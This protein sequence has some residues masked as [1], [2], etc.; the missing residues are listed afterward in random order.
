MRRAGCP[1][2]TSLDLRLPAPPRGIS[3]R[4]RVLPRPP[5]PRHPPCALLAE[6]LIRLRLAQSASWPPR[7]AGPARASRDVASLPATRPSQPRT[8]P[9]SAIQTGVGPSP[10]RRAMRPRPRPDGL[11]LA[12]SRGSVLPVWQRLAV[13]CGSLCV[14]LFRAVRAGDQ[15]RTTLPTPE[16]ALG[17]SG[18]TP[19]LISRGRRTARVPRGALSRCIEVVRPLQRSARPRTAEELSRPLEVSQPPH[20]VVRPLL[21]NQRMGRSTASRAA[22]RKGGR[23][24]GGAAGIRTPDLRRAR[25]AL[26]RLSYGPRHRSRPHPAS[27]PDS[28]WA[29]LDSNQGPRPY[30]GRALTA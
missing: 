15:T 10:P 23:R 29:R 18:R 11:R 6:A 5:T 3:P 17:R 8:P 19:V 25:A 14:C 2:R 9:P 4:G 12:V 28:G 7:R 20:E 30:Q 16:V 1:I 26:S 24:R 21:G 13:V 27:T 22:P